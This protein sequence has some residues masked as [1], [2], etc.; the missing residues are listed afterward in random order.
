LV[1]IHL[2]PIYAENKNQDETLNFSIDLDD[3]IIDEIIEATQF[4][5]YDPK[6]DNKDGRMQIE[7]LTAV[8]N[9]D[10]KVNA[11]LNPLSWNML[12]IKVK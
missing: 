6:Q 2:L 10:T 7:K 12:R 11:K 3:L 9:S 5:G 8:S 4:S 1:T